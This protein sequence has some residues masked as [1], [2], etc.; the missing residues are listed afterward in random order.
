MVNAMNKIL[1]TIG[2]L[3]LCIGSQARA[4]ILEGFE[5]EHKWR[6]ADWGD[7]A[8]VDSATETWSE[9]QKSLKIHWQEGSKRKG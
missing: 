7:D 4:D 5:G 3:T 6:V 1:G 9:G 2:F 8:K